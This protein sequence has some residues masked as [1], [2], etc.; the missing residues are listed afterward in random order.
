MTT[1]SYI[2]RFEGTHKKNYNSVLI[3]CTKE[4]AGVLGSGL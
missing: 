4:K 2:R 3:T 1:G